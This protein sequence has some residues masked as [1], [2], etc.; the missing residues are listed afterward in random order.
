MSGINSK[1][2]VLVQARP[3]N[4]SKLFSLVQTLLCEH[5]LL[6][7]ANLMSAELQSRGEGESGVEIS[8][9]WIKW[10]CTFPLGVMFNREF[11]TL[12]FLYRSLD[13]PPPKKKSILQR[14]TEKQI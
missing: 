11:S 12:A 14:I 9:S 10:L 2:E 8:L 7:F 5:Y 6:P 4:F 3:I 1:V 13:L